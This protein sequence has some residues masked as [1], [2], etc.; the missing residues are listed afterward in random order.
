MMMRDDSNQCFC[1]RFFRIA[2]RCVPVCALSPPVSSVQ[3]VENE[4]PIFL[5]QN[6][7]ETHPRVE[8]RA[9]LRY[10]IRYQI[11][12]AYDPTAISTN[13]GDLFPTT[14]CRRDGVFLNRACLLNQYSSLQYELHS[15]LRG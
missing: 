10:Q 11:G 6:T 4:A 15:P 1:H 12:L 13:R 5:N 7:V 9:L 2:G 14:A 3:S 8:H